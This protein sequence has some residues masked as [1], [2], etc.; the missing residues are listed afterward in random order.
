VVNLSHLATEICASPLQYDRLPM[1]E[2]NLLR[3]RNTAAP[4][5][6]SMHNGTLMMR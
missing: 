4:S 1:F 2:Y 6:G 5:R 3:G